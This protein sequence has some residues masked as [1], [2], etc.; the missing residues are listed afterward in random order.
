MEQIYRRALQCAHFSVFCCT[1][2]SSRCSRGLRFDFVQHRSVV[3]HQHL[4]QRLWVGLVLADFSVNL[5][6]MG[7]ER[8][9]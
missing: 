2:D 7:N 9:Q 8:L 6:V 1:L 4:S 3:Q 5:W